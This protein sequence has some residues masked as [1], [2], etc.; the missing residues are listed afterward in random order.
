MNQKFST[1]SLSIFPISL[2]FI[3]MIFVS[4]ILKSQPAYS[5]KMSK[6]TLLYIEYYEKGME[7]NNKGDQKTTK[8]Y[9]EK[10][11]EL[12]FKNKWEDSWVQNMMDLA[13][14]ELYLGNFE[15]S[16]ALYDS[17]IIL[18]ENG[19]INKHLNKFKIYD[20][21]S[22]LLAQEGDIASSN[23][24]RDK[25]ELT[26]PLLPLRFK[27][28]SFQ[29]LENG[30]AL[31][32][33]RYG[34]L[35]KANT[36]F[37]YSV[38][39][40]HRAFKDGA[41]EGR[42]DEYEFAKVIL[43]KNVANNDIQAGNFSKAKIYL[44]SALNTFSVLENDPYYSNSPMRAALQNTLGEYYLG[45]G[46][47]DLAKF[48][49]SSR[50]EELEKY[51]N[52]I[53][54]QMRI[55][56][57]QNLAS[58][59]LKTQNYDSARIHFE[60]SKSY[61]DQLKVAEPV[62]YK[63]LTP[64]INFYQIIE[65]HRQADEFLALIDF[66]QDPIRLYYSGA[67]SEIITLHALK[68]NS[69]A[70]LAFQGKKAPDLGFLDFNK[71]ALSLSEEISWLID[72]GLENALKRPTYLALNSYLTNLRKIHLQDPADDFPLLEAVKVI[73]FA[74]NQQF[75]I[76]KKFASLWTGDIDPVLF[77]EEKKL[78]QRKSE[79]EKL[80][81]VDKENQVLDSL[82]KVSHELENVREKLFDRQ[83][84]ESG[85]GS[86]DDQSSPIELAKMEKDQQEFHYYY[87]DFTLHIITR[88]ANPEKWKWEVKTNANLDSIIYLAL[89][90]F[91]NQ[92][93]DSRLETS[94]ELYEIL[95]KDYIQ[96]DTKRLIIHPFG[97]IGLLP[98]AALVNENGKYLIE[99]YSISFKNGLKLQPRIPFFESKPRE[100]LA[101]APY[102][103][104]NSQAVQR[105]LY[106]ALDGT[107]EELMGIRKFYK[108]IAYEG[109]NATKENFLKESK[110]S[111]IIHVATHAFAEANM[112]FS[113]IVFSG[114]KE[115]SKHSLFG[116]EISEMVLNAEM[117]I[118]SAC[119][120]G[121]GKFQLGEGIS[122]LAKL[123]EN[124]GAKSLVYTLWKID[125][126]ASANLMTYF[127]ENLDKG[128][129]KDLALQTAQVSYLKD[130]KGE[131]DHPYYWAGYT[132]S[133]DLSPIKSSFSYIQLFI[134]L[135]LVI[136]IVWG[137]KIY[138]FKAK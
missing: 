68:A 113:K 21:Y 22:G 36:G 119:Q 71:K 98:F 86:I 26:I 130:N 29:K 67:G 37:L 32:S 137:I 52:R 88:T 23:I 111:K 46:D 69:M 126:Y 84:G 118:L 101:F 4:F 96:K 55:E 34:D 95:L 35:G 82:M 105:S 132:L 64:I 28:A 56:A 112:L 24:Y 122:S 49:M 30:K 65:E 9:I 25:A 76:R 53:N 75:N 44:D 136:G 11:S 33:F 13:S 79:L 15:G 7:Y 90:Q 104:E 115:E 100:V 57:R 127:Y 12:A 72:A 51:D 42:E 40:L 117:M 83:E 43:Y 124:A 62:K 109:E 5:Q 91:Q 107:R 20:M 121:Y 110:D 94:K 14:F 128:M 16:R 54:L 134:G 47:I 27:N 114:P 3:L 66:D 77:A 103:E 129:S 133:G 60:K 123:F 10:L 97:N 87:S 116:Y 138:F 19:T 8:G 102:F 106:G 17:M 92:S 39:L 131:K 93:S 120:T 41:Y 45:L 59:F 73:D 48:H 85:F 135:V 108:T 80:Y 61:V 31:N 70:N 6:D 50:V 1:F 2:L 99:D 58:L 78:K 125:D 38:D 18:T 74:K 89:D 81:L 63:Y